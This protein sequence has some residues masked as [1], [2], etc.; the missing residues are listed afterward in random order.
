MKVALSVLRDM[1]TNAILADEVGL[2]KTIE[3]G[4]ILKELILREMVHSVLIIVPKALL[5]QWKDELRE[6]F[7][8]DFMKL[9]KN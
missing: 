6:K 9:Q 5:N 3:A 2:G 1:N 7:G 4:M 8:E